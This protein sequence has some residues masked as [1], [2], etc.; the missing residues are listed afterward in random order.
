M[1]VWRM[2]V[3]RMRVWRIP[4]ATYWGS[5]SAAARIRSFP[6]I[7]RLHPEMCP[8]PVRFKLVCLFV[9][10]RRVWVCVLVW[11]KFRNSYKILRV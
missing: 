3:W 11:K 1:P 7:W 10:E 9:S 2:P 5:K 6:S 8:I 4:E